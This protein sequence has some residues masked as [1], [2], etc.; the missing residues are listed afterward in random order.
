MDMLENYRA[1]IDKMDSKITALLRKR[2]KV[3]RKIGL[4]KA[5]TKKPIRDKNR[6]QTIF[7][8]LNTDFEREV[9]KA[10]LRESKKIQNT[11]I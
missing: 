11:R 9:F 3:V 5:K 2:E 10:I 6:E 1:R 7:S 4:L 8:R